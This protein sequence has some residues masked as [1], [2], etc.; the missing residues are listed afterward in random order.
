MNIVKY[1]TF[2][3]IGSYMWAFLG[4][5]GGRYLT[6]LLGD[7]AIITIIGVLIISGIVALVSHY[8]KKQSI[9]FVRMRRICHKLLIQILAYSNPHKYSLPRLTSQQSLILRSYWVPFRLSIP[10]CILNY[11]SHRTLHDDFVVYVRM[12]G[13]EPPR[14]NGHQN[15]NLACLPVS[16]HAHDRQYNRKDY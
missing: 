3:L 5:Y 8:K 6:K 12:R 2:I 16:A 14:P 4:I 1:C 7:Y 13:I 9:G 15:L 11:K 10:L